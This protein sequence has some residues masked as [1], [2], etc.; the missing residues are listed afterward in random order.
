[1]HYSLD[2]CCLLTL[3]NSGLDS[4]NMLVPSGHPVFSAIYAHSPGVNY[5]HFI[6]TMADNPQL[7]KFCSVSYL[8]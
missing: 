1:M 3:K 6:I 2:T 5:S 8:Q 4:A 7:Q